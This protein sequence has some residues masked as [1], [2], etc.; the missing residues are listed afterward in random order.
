MGE[1]PLPRLALMGNA[2]MDLCQG[3]SCLTSMARTTGF[4][5]QRPIGCA[6]LSE[7]R[8][9]RLRSSEPG[10][11][12]ACEKGLQ[13]KVKACA[14]TCHGSADR[15]LLVEAGKNH[16]H[17][18]GGQAFDGAVDLP[19]VVKPIQ[20]SKQ[21]QPVAAFIAPAGLGQCDGAIAGALA[22]RWRA[23]VFLAKELLIALVNAPDD[24]LDSLGIKL[25]PAGKPRRALEFRDM[26]FQ[27]VITDVAWMAVALPRV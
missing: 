7:G 17:T 1:V 16:H 20:A 6:D 3:E 22:K 24:V 11:I 27:L 14:F 13:P 19:G 8:V 23:A 10:A 12:T 9:Q 18:P 15:C 26:A 25:L 2:S 5:C 21:P 4:S